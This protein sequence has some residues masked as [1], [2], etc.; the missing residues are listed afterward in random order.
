MKL[1]YFRFALLPVLLTGCANVGSP[2]PTIATNQP[3][4][5]AE[6]NTPEMVHHSAAESKIVEQFVGLNETEARTL[7]KTQGR[8]F[9]VGGRDGESIPVIANFVDGRITVELANGIVV[10]ASVELFKFR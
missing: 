2:Q 8:L 5:A 6:E 10:Q 1:V 4:A 7:A 9:T 3:V